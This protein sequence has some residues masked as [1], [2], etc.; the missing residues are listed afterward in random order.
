MTTDDLAQYVHTVM[1]LEALEDEVSRFLVNPDLE[2]LARLRI[3]Y[4]Q[5]KRPT[6]I[7]D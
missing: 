7:K 3:A 1:N 5:L 4:S 6:T 2:A